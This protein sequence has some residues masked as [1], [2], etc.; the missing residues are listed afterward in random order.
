MPD[1]S[2]QQY[3]K[4]EDERTRPAR[5]LLA[6][7]PL[8]EARAVFDL[9]CGPGNST[10]LLAAR[11]PKAA[12]T[13]IDSSPDML[14]QARARLPAGTFLQADLSDWAVPVGVDLLF[15]NATFQWVPDH[16]SVL[17]RL[18]AS[19]APGAMLAVQMPDNVNEPSHRLMQ[20]VAEEGA[21]AETLAAARPARPSLPPVES[22][23]DRLRPFCRRLDIWHGVYHHVLADAGAIVEWV[24][25]SGLR[26]YLDPLDADVRT[27][28]LA[29]YTRRIA[30]AYPPRPDGKVI[31]HFPR[32]FL[33][34]TR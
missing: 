10:E 6:Q 15:S 22:Y 27:E 9:G 14:Q 16:L 26:P 19:L 2:A 17:A 33:V 25:G 20:E 29:L 3:L 7:V 21:W 30:E 4:F 8:Q 28:F 31:L 1:W 18:L 34:A 12:L 13:G 23:Y 11:F 24:R 5:D 32:L